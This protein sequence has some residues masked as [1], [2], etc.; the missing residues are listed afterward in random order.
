[1]GKEQPKVSLAL[2]SRVGTSADL[3]CWITV[4]RSA[5]YACRK[6]GSAGVGLGGWPGL[7]ESGEFAGD[8]AGLGGA[9]ALEDFQGPAQEGRGLGGVADG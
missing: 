3:L 1:M 5:L 7:G 2:L 8:V 6:R 9:D 4:V